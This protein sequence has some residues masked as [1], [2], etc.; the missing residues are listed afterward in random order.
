[1]EKHIVI[2]G[3][4]MA[5]L[6]A[7]IYARLNG[8][9]A[10]IVE[11]GEHAGG[12]CTAWDREGYRFDHCI[13]WLVGT[14]S[15]TF[16]RI[17]EELGALTPATR[18][19]DHEVFTRVVA[20]DGSD[21][22][23]HSNIDQW[24]KYLLQVAPEDAQAIHRMIADMRSTSSMEQ[25]EDAPGLRSVVDY[26]KAGVHMGGALLTLGKHGRQSC[27]EYFDE[28][29]FTNPR[30]KL[31]FDN[32]YADMPFSAAA[33]LMMLAW[34][35]QKN[36]GYP[37][38]GSLPFAQRIT[39]RFLSLGGELRLGQRVKHIVLEPKSGG[40]SRATG[41]ELEDGSV[42]P[43]GHVIS[44]ADAHSTIYGLLNGHF[45]TPHIHEAFAHWATFTPLV[46]VCFGIDGEVPATFPTT[47]V[48]ARGERIGST[49]LR[50]GFNVMNYAFDP[51][52]APKGKTSIILRFE[53]PWELW[54]DLDGAAYQEEKKRILAD[55]TA[56]LL[57]LHPEIAG[58]IAVTDITTPRTDVRYTG[59]W[60]GAYEGFLPGPDNF[61]K[62]LEM[63]LPG[64]DGFT[65]IGQWVFPGGGL[66]PA[67]QSGKWAIQLL[68]KELHQEFVTA[69]RTTA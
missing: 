8:F 68:C 25:F 41:I 51:T 31:F 28:L 66:P 67:A 16:H 12:Q 56:R 42:I 9:K 37:I 18:I 59:V 45:I 53:S 15:G 32:L 1:M 54:K 44:A 63:R 48:I 7:G 60:Q 17:W 65:L 43:A 69:Q 24:E 47:T 30:L 36:A 11:M 23:V 61:G 5:G 50:T 22:L 13:H 52:M 3:G 57:K 2:I 35:S 38:G 33:F 46:Q 19:V 6:S 20:P 21:F 14:S 55:A 27:R 49:E 40:G 39:D 10:T 62:T 29:G 64:L 4:G 26:V 58:H 34:F